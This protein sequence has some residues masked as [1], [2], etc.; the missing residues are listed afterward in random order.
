MLISDRTAGACDTATVAVDSA[1]PSVRQRPTADTGGRRA[2]LTAY[3]IRQVKLAWRTIIVLA[4]AGAL[5]GCYIG[6]SHVPMGVPLAP[7]ERTARGLWHLE[8][9]LHLPDE[10]SVQRLVLSDRGLL[11]F[12]NNY[13][14]YAHFFTMLAF[15]LVMHAFGRRHVAKFWTVFAATNVISMVIGAFLPV[16]PPRLLPR[17][18]LVDT[19]DLYGPHV[20][21]TSGDLS[22]VANQFFSMP[23]VHFL[24]ALIVAWSVIAFFPRLGPVRWAAVAYPF[25]TLCA[26]VLTG[27]HYWMDC[28][29]AALILLAVLGCVRFW[30]AHTG[31]R[32]KQ[33]AR[34]TGT[35]LALLMTGYGLI[36]LTVALSG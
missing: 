8:R 35:V 9:L 27:N 13:Y 3:L 4:I 21:S 24:W 11:I 20:Y 19:L 23:S 34:R 36:E 33:Y 32:T 1:A 25:L 14:I 22:D 7:G 31:S 5:L 28:I 2:A 26:I 17:S 15:V 30:T 12:L 10:A 16:A 29:V 6:T 18:H